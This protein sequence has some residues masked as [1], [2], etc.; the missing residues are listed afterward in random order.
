MAKKFVG[1]E[2]M[3]ATNGKGLHQQSKGHRI[4]AR[5]T[6]TCSTIVTAISV[7]IVAFCLIFQ[8]CPVYGSSMMTTLNPIPN[9]YTDTALACMLGQPKDGDIVIMKLYLQNSDDGDYLLASRGDTAALARLRARYNDPS[10]SQQ[11]ATERLNYLIKYTY[12]ES[13]SNGYFEYIVKRLIAKG[14]DRLSMRRI[15]DQY[16]LYL[17]GEQLN[18]DYLDPLVSSHDAPNFVQLWKILSGTAT[19]N[20]LA[21]W[22]TTDCQALLTT[23][24]DTGVGNGVPST[25]MMTIPDNYYFLM[26]DNRG[27]L[28]GVYGYSKSWDSTAFGPLPTSNYYSV[29]VDVLDKSTKMPNY[30]WQK[31]VYYVCFGWAWQK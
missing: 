16:Y 7:L 23:N 6:I 31:F 25:Y 5:T 11:N 10:Y 13:D 29:C 20:D 12:P 8:M 9:D 1:Q 18:E 22:V 14:G 2:Y 4:L 17:N 30:I 27:T 24:T 15:D 21:D 19:K 3:T 26:G 28:D